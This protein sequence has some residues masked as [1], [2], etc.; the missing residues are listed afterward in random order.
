M[1]NQIMPIP[2]TQA[3]KKF[4][5]NLQKVRKGKGI[6]QEKLA[7]EIGVHRTYLSLVEK[8]DRNPSLRTI[9]RLSKALN[10]H[11]SKLLSF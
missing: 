9:Y 3:L 8:G 11:S 1:V 10:V 4:G 7:E 6:S 2:Y 5:E